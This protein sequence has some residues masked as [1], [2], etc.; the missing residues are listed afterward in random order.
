MQYRYNKKV[1][2]DYVQLIRENNFNNGIMCDTRVK[3]LGV[4]V[5]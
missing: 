2:E 1:S 5:R 3:D 4:S